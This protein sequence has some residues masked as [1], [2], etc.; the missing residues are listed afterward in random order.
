MAKLTVEIVTGERVVYTEDDVDMVIAPGSDGTLGI[1][2]RHAPLITT[3]AHGELRV[4]KGN[5]EQSLVVFGGFMEVTGEKVIVLADTAE[6][7]EE[8]DL[9]RA[10]ASRSRAEDSIRNRGSGADL[11][12]AELSLRRAAVRLQVGQRRRRG[13][14]PGLG[15]GAD[16]EI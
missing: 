9:A 3:L 15:T 5:S 10:E 8:I 4:K 13:R 12:E 11:A 7:A 2:P 1:L 6:R 16:N 14:G